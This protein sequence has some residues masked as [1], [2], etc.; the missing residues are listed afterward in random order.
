[1]AL[2]FYLS[3]T[4]VI[5]LY[6][7][8]VGVVGVV[9]R[10]IVAISQVHLVPI[11]RILLWLS[12]IF[13]L[14]SPSPLLADVKTLRF[15][16]PAQGANDS[17]PMFGK[18]AGATVIYLYDDVNRYTTNRLYG[19]YSVAEAIAI[20][21]KDTGLKAVFS[22]GRHLIISQ[23][24]NEEGSVIAVKEKVLPLVAVGQKEEKSQE[25]N[26]RV[27]EE[28]MVTAQKRSE[29]IQTIPAT[30]SALSSDRLM[31]RG[32]SNG[33]DLQYTVPGLVMG[34]TVVG[35]VQVSIRG[36]GSE[37]IAVGGDPGV[38]LHINGHYI[39]LSSYMLQDFFDIER[40]EVQRGPQGTLYGRNAIGGNINIITNRPT[41]TFES[42]V[43]LAVGN[44]N[45]KTAQIMVS[46][47]LSKNL[48]GRMA[49]YGNERDGYVNNIVTGQQLEDADHSS[50]RAM[51]EYEF[52]ESITLLAGAYRYKDRSSPTG[53]QV[54]GPYPG[55][56]PYEGI[57]YDNISAI[58]P[59]KLRA[60]A[61]SEGAE[62]AEGI[63]L[64]LA[65]RLDGVV[66]KSLSAYNDADMSSIIDDDGT[67]WP[68]AVQYSALGSKTFSQEFQ[69]LSVEESSTK[70]IVGLFYFEEEADYVLNLMTPGTSVDFMIGPALA[71]TTS[72]AVFGQIDYP[73][74]ET[75]NL[76]AGLRYSKDEKDVYRQLFFTL[77]GINPLADQREFLSD[78][79]DAVT[80]MMSV[81]YAL[82]DNSM[83]YAM[84]SRG[85]KSGGFNSDS[86]MEPSYDPEFLDAYEIGVK[87]RLM[88]DR[89]ELNASSFYYDY[90]DKTESK[91]D[92]VP[93]TDTLMQFFSNASSASILGLELEGQ[94]LITPY[95]SVDFSLAFQQ[96]KYDDFSSS[97]PSLPDLGEQDLAGNHL[98]RAP[99]KTLHVGAEYL[100]VLTNGLG[101]LT[102]RLD[103]AWIDEQYFNAFNLETA[104]ANSYH[105]SNAR[106]SW[107]NANANIR[108]EL[109][110]LN[111]E[112]DS[113]LSNIL[114]AGESFGFARFGSYLPPRTYGA[115]ASYYF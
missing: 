88:D 76:T 51:L 4:Y 61:I 99:E 82:S 49:F 8:V 103:Y 45:D 28:V 74:S 42:K 94:A 40:V 59:L 47:P 83:L 21:L 44:Y 22:K 77:D 27:L 35:S 75:L 65:W 5:S 95:F 1:M 63:S 72:Y 66:F 29:N 7:R 100:W 112:D 13:C 69:W 85:Y 113:T 43:G 86:P 78:E 105:R 25:K 114:V 16:I 58:D 11:M 104:K 19:N 102:A 98:P 115:S 62:N 91:I 20:L 6:H 26:A 101:R 15:S 108:I 10:V 41:E 96:S 36:V 38:P 14:F 2:G 90:S 111:I 30:I 107:E 31:S 18:Q 9:G 56:P 37:N 12:L 109:Y 50:V 87:T 68:I 73:L 64:D 32:V 54:V 84:Y 97:D 48:R 33:S 24:D 93:G 80:G 71:D 81:D 57:P 92:E 106:L 70:W 23:A 55:L 39:Q 53:V 52:T 34:D 67:D 46:G 79:W 3:I 110:V 17:L 60:D 89:V